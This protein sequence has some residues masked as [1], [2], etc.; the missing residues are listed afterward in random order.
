MISITS[1]KLSCNTTR[2]N[3]IDTGDRYEYQKIIQFLRNNF[4]KDFKLHNHQE[5]IIVKL[6]N[7]P[8][9]VVQAGAKPRCV[10]ITPGTR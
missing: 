7:Y 1:V 4:N 5:R 2:K 6:Y 3:S 8:D 10:G 9:G